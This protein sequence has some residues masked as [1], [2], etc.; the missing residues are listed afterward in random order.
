MGHMHICTISYDGTGGESG[1]KEA[2]CFSEV[3][4]SY[5]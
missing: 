4:Y 3:S 1:D 2:A 5:M